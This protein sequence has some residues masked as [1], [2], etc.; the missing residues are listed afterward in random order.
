VELT[1]ISS[2]ARKQLVDLRS[3]PLGPGWLR[4]G[5]SAPEHLEDAGEG[6]WRTGPQLRFRQALI[7][8]IDGARDVVLLCSFLLADDAIT[9]AI[10]RAAARGVRAY[11]LT[12]SEQRIGKT[13]RDDESFEQRMITEHKRMLAALAG[14]ILL[15]SAEHIH[16]KFL[17]VDPRSATAARAWLSTANFNRALRDGIELGVQLDPA[18]TRALADCFR[19]AFWNEAERELRGPDRLFQ[20]SRALASP[21][22]PLDDRIYATTQAGARLGACVVALIEGAQRDL[23]VASYGLAADHPAVTALVA[24]ARRGVRVTVLTRPRGAVAAGVAALAGAGITVLAHDNLHAKAVVADGRA[25][26]M[27]ANLEA[28][29]LDHGFEVGA[30]LP[31]SLAHSVEET[32]REWSAS[33]PWIYR[34]DATRGDHLGDFLPVAAK[35]RDG[36]VRITKAHEQRAPDVTASDALALEDAPPPLLQPSAPRGELPQQV[37]LLWTVKAPT[38]PRGSVERLQEVERT[39]DDPATSRSPA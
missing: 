27:S 16:A 11:V 37:T 31:G 29:G 12:A 39:G 33:F 6:V 25:L 21:A 19:W 10:L 3:E 22:P 2:L 24:A 7:A 35:L 34:G 18:A 15:R 14:K 28:H 26:V 4:R 9:Q 17:V 5:P 30:L 20:V 38:L 32:L 8:A 13:V 1:M 23:V 36:I